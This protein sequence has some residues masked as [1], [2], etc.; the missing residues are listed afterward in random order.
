MIK[1][2][3]IKASDGELLEKFLLADGEH[4]K[5][6]DISFWLPPSD[7]QVKHKGVDYLAV[8]DEKG[9][10]FFIRLENILRMHCQFAPE[11]EIAR[12]RPAV[13][14]F[15]KLIQRQARDQYKQLIFESVS[16]SLIWFLRKFGFRRSKNEVVCDLG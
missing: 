4:S 10:I 16:L 2:R 3:P 7:C 13:A 9:V 5:T 15:A 12:T 6:S 14:E 11:T 8:E 1:C